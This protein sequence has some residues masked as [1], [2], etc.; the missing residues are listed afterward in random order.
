MIEQCCHQ[1]S[2]FLQQASCDALMFTSDAPEAFRL[3][4]SEAE[5]MLELGVESYKTISMSLSGP[6]IPALCHR[7]TISNTPWSMALLQCT[8][9]YN[10][11][12]L[13]GHK[14]SHLE[15]SFRRPPGMQNHM[16]EHEQVQENIFHYMKN[17]GPYQLSTTCVVANAHGSY[18]RWPRRSIQLQKSHLQSPS[19]EMQAQ[20]SQCQGQQNSRCTPSSCVLK[21]RKLRMRGCRN[22][23]K[24]SRRQERRSLKRTHR[25]RRLK[26][27]DRQRP[28]CPP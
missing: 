7:A 22:V 20:R 16:L 3:H 4:S 2:R 24:E 23:R 13:K 8:K 18:L 17:L 28:S 21:A 12:E 19:F 27:R 11:S 26:D 10:G 14:R 25:R 9:A 1:R 5:C 15:S 6:H